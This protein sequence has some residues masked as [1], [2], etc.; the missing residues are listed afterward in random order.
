MQIITIK[1][2]LLNNI[3]LKVISSI[4]GITFW[5][6]ISQSHTMQLHLQIPVSF[7]N[8]RA[9]VAID[10]PETIQVTLRGLRANLQLLDLE[11]LAVHID[12]HTLLEGPNAM[13][14][15]HA[16]LFLP[17]HINVVHYSPLNSVINVQSKTTENICAVEH[18]TA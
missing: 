8:Q 11:S 7:Y 2:L 6:I 4:I 14:V 17:E 18:T 10:A 12:A 16:T 13:I 3:V 1:N 15:N 5:F 9:D